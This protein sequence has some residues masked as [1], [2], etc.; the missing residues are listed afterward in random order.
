MSEGS[1]RMQVA[2]QQGPKVFHESVWWVA[3]PGGLLQLISL[4]V[5]L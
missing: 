2:L 4:H 5:C 1:K 3:D